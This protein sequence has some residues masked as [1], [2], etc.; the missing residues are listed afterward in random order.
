MAIKNISDKIANNSAL[1]WKY[2]SLVK[3]NNNEMMYSETCFSPDE[4][5][6]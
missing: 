2:S 1:I 4:Q 6:S 3:D 5:S